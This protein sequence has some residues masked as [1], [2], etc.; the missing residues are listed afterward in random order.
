[1]EEKLKLQKAELLRQIKFFEA[2]SKNVSEIGKREITTV[3]VSGNE[4]L[5]LTID[6][7]L[8]GVLPISESII[9]SIDEAIEKN[10][11]VLND[12]SILQSLKSTK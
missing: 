1:M 7:I 2:L 8:A 3:L 5:V 4:G 9:T 10:K 12:N 6:K 11:T